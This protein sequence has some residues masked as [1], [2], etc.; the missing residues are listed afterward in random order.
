MGMLL[1]V[2]PGCGPADPVDAVKDLPDTVTFAAHI[3]PLVRT[4]CMP[5]HSPG[6]AGPFA[7]TTYDEVRRKAR[8]VRHVTRE[9][10]MPPWPAAR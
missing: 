9:R 3:A 2:L 10:Y 1:A 7:L 6:H 8:T 4:H 5:C